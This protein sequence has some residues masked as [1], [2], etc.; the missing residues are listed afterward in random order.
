MSDLI[1]KIAQDGGTLPPTQ[2]MEVIAESIWN[3]EAS[4]GR[5][6]HK[7]FI[8][9]TYDYEQ[10]FAAVTGESPK[11]EENQ[12]IKLLYQVAFR[13]AIRSRMFLLLGIYYV[14]SSL[15]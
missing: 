15:I 11:V 4:M 13:Q 1:G 2:A 9:H 12:Y 8:P 6:H 14:G 5:V 10:D 3:C 7:A